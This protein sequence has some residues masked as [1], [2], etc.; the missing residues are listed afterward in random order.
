MATLTS[1]A[2]FE[3]LYQE[4]VR[5]NGGLPTLVADQYNTPASYYQ[6]TNEVTLSPSELAQLQA[7]QAQYNRQYALNTIAQEIS[8]N[9]FTNPYNARSQ[10]AISNLNSITSIP[11]DIQTYSAVIDPTVPGGYRMVPNAIL[12]S[13]VYNQLGGVRD[14]FSPIL[15]AGIAAAVYA[16][17]SELTGIDI[18]KIILGAGLVTAGIAMFGDLQAHTNDQATDIPGKINEIDQ[19]TGLQKSFGEL[20][21]DSCSLF[22]ELMG[23]MSGSFDGVL[24]FIEGGI[25]SFKDFM[26]NSALGSVLNQIGSVVSNIISQVGMVAS[27]II[28]LAGAAINNILEQTGLG[29]L[30]NSLGNLASGIMGG[31]ADMASQ[32]ANEISGLVNMAADIASKLA[33]LGLAGAMMDPCKLAV[34]LNT[35]S[36]ALSNAATQLTSPLESAIPNI[37]IPTETDTRAN[38]NEVTAAIQSARENAQQMPGVPQ[39]PFGAIANLYSPFSAYLHNLIGSVSGIFGD[40]IEKVADGNVLNVISSTSPNNTALSSLNNITSGLSGTVGSISDNIISIA[41]GTNTNTISASQNITG[42]NTDDDDFSTGGAE[43][44]MPGPEVYDDAILRQSRNPEPVRTNSESNTSTR[45]VTENTAEGTVST[46]E[47]PSTQIA[48]ARSHW[49]KQY[50]ARYGRIVRDSRKLG[51]EIT[52][53]LNEAKFRSPAQKNEASVLREDVQRIMRETTSYNKTQRAKFEYRSRTQDRDENKEKE[54]LNEYNTVMQSSNNLFL[55]RMENSVYDA[56]QFWNS[57]KGQAI[58]G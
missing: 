25:D 44:N 31:I 22:N 15:N 36:P 45:I 20:S 40:T 57:L 56:Q 46:I 18:E 30:L 28:A 27:S 16:G 23:I 41:Q 38:P 8:D 4:F 13:T 9:N 52:T 47:G 42:S 33:A 17:L 1:E 35:G 19:L 53:Y 43:S 7:K 3:R 49:K 34:L 6:A 50:Q 26:A 29:D 21:N 54:I 32:I 51:R 5:R 12:Q 55:E 10:A 11:L 37:N 14:A 48:K 24:D 58:L 2:E 39:S